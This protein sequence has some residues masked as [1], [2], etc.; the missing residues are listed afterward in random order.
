MTTSTPLAPKPPRPGETLL[1]FDPGARPDAG[2]A[3]VGRLRSPW[4]PGDCPKNLREARA[5]GGPF[6]IE[7]DSPYRAGVEGLEPGRWVFILAWFDKAR[8]DLIRQHPSH[9]AEPAGTFALRSPVRPNPI[10]VTLVRILAM[11]PVTGRIKIDATD[12]F[13][14]TPVLDI[15]PWIATVDAPLPDGP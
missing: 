1:P 10:S 12:A 11:D 13:D 14:G 2:L 7:L 5:H 15:K 8:R 9:R 3:F 6:A 4:T